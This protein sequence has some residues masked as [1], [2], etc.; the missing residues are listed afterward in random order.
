M[1][2]SMRAVVVDQPGPPEALRVREVPKPTA[3]EG[4]VLIRVA[5]FGLNRSELHFRQGVAYSGSFPRIPGIEAAGVVEEA[6][7]GEFPRGTQVVTMMGGMG[8]DFDGGYAEYVLVPARQVIAF[9]SDLPW[10]VVGAVPEMLQTA[11]GSLTAGLD[12]REGQSVLIR[13]GTSSIGLA[14]TVLA[15]LRGMTVYATTRRDAARPL[16]EVTGADH[17]LIDDGDIAS[18][19]RRIEPAGRATVPI[20]RVYRMHEIA[21]AHHDM[22][23]GTV[24]GKA[25]VLT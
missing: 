3:A 15:K 8:R 6:P 24:G 22:E 4:Q 21:R 11:N 17:V 2:A 7:G 12:A 1:S 18:R 20:G 10:H 5:A 25:V 16:L 13:G 23:E 9:T 14:A 19:V